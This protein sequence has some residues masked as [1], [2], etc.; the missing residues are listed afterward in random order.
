MKYKNYLTEITKI[1]R[2]IFDSVNDYIADFSET[3]LKDSLFRGSSSLNTTSVIVKQSDSVRTPKIA[4]L[5]ITALVDGCLKEVN[6][7]APSRRRSTICSNDKEWAEGFGSVL[8][9]VF[10]KDGTLLA[11]VKHYDFNRS[12]NI[13]DMDEDAQLALG[14]KNN[15]EF[16][17]LA[18]I[19]KLILSKFDRFEDF[20]KEAYILKGLRGDIKS[21]AENILKRLDVHL[22][23]N[24]S[25][26]PKSKCEIWFDG[27]C[28]MTNNK[29]FDE[30]ETY[31]EMTIEEKNKKDVK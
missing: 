5:F 2:Q 11:Y 6:P 18:D 13:N 3:K 23:N 27:D 17:S 1:E 28:L 15:D 16:K 19:E 7:K 8:Y 9:R 12:A 22:A 31:V 25:E 20:Y 29:Y 30:F 24:A 26:L 21:N 10:P 14:Y 4:S